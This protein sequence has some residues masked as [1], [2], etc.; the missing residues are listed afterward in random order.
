MS[1]LRHVRARWPDAEVPTGSPEWLLYELDE[2][3]DAVTR[4]VELFPDG[5]VSRNSIQIEERGGKPCPAL[6][7]VSL[8]DGFAGVDLEPITSE[9]FERAWARGRDT[10]FWN[11]T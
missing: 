6:I 8:A 5:S 10:P 9:E 3:A 4:T 2:Q 7:D 11:V 1:D